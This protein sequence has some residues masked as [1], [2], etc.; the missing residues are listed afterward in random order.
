MRLFYLLFV[1]IGILFS[2][3][4][5]SESL[6]MRMLD[7][8]M[9]ECIIIRAGDKAMVVD[10]AYA[11]N[12]RIVRLALE[13]MGIEEIDYLVLTHPHADHIG[14]TV[15]LLAHTRMKKALLP[16][17]EYASE[18]YAKT[19]N[20]LDECD[21]ERVYPEVGDIYYLGDAQITILGPHPVAYAEENNW[22]IILM[23]E[24]AGRRILLTG[25]ME[26]EAEMDLLLYSDVYPLKADVLKV[27]HHGS[28]TSSVFAFIEAVS[29]EHALISCD[30]NE[31]SSYPHV[32]TALA[33]V[34]CGVEMI[35]TTE[36]YGN[37]SV[38]IDSLGRMD[39]Y[40][41]YSPLKE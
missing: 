39:V 16:P 28:N 12:A 26:A 24:Y 34:D 38:L 33:L 7:V 8:G 10:T 32:D 20:A 31:D 4:A 2:T 29:P 36:V 22:S 1:F 19:I 14:G 13:D 37:I 23:I 21:V 27:A 11:K 35:W 17:I 5:C 30:S 18:T 40:S 25:D 41:D 15:E 9:A 6:E 3:S